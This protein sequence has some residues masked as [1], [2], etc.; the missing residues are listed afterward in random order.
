MDDLRRTVD[1]AVSDDYASMRA[2]YYAYFRELMK[3]V[4]PE[5]D[6]LTE[7]RVDQASLT[8]AKGKLRRLWADEQAQ[9]KA[10]AGARTWS[11]VE[12]GCVTAAMAGT[13][14]L[15]LA[16][17]LPVV[18]AGVG[19][20]SFAGWAISRWRRQPATAL[21]LSGATM[22]VEA[23]RQPGWLDPQTR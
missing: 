8:W 11:R 17:A 12:V 13:V 1:L 23:S 4:I 5:E 14:G 16:P 20:L 21:T 15:S 6:D 22:F 19:I 10:A 18:G 9:V 7:V 3:R 2:E